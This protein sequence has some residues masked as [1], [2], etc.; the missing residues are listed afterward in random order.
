MKLF[1]L[2]LNTTFSFLEST[3]TVDNAIKKAVEDK[4]EYLIFSEKNNFFSL[5]EAN[6]KC[7]EVGI[8][9]VFGLEISTKID[10]LVFDYNLFAKNQKAFEELKVISYKLLSN[11]QLDIQKCIQE[12]PDIIFIEHPHNSYFKQTGKYINKPNY[13]IG[14]SSSELGEYK[15][16]LSAFNFVIFN[17]FNALNYGDY[18]ILQLLKKM[19]SQDQ[20]II[21]EESLNFNLDSN[22]ISI[23]S[24]INKT[25]ELVKSLYF[26]IEYKNY[27]L[28]KF[29]NPEG[30]SSKDYLKKLISQKIKSLGPVK[31]NEIYQKRL[32]HEYSIITNL[33]FEDYFL[34]MQDWISWAKNNNI[35]IGPGRGS[36]AGSLVSYLLGITEIDPIKY[37][38]IFERFLNPKRINMPDIDVDVQDDKR[39]LIIKYL[40]DK[41][42]YDKVA[43]IVTFSTLGKKSA[44]RDVLRAY[45]I[46][47]NKINK[48]SKLISQNDISLQEEL[49]KNI[50]LV[51]E[52]A[53]LKPDD[54]TFKD[55]IVEETSKISGFYRQSGTHAAGIVISSEKII[56]SVP[57]YKTDDNIQQT[58]VSMEFLENY[59]LIKMDILGLKTLTT[60]KEIESNIENKYSLKINWEQIDCNDQKTFELLSNGN[61]AG[62][63]QVESPIMI[64]ALKKIKVDSFEDIATIISINRPGPISHLKTFSDRKQKIEPVPLVSK[65]YDK[66]VAPTYGIIVYQEQ[67]MEIVQKVANMSF[68]EA[69]LLRRIISKKKSSEMEAIEE[70]FI[71]KAIQ[72][73]YDLK[74][75]K[76][77]FKNISKFA[78]YGFN[79]SH[80]IAYAMLT[81]K[82]A[83]LKANYPLE[84]FTSCISSA[85]GAQTTISKYVNE[86]KKMHIGIISPNINLSCANAAIHDNKIVLPLSLIKG[87]GPEIIKLIEQNRQANGTYKNFLHCIFC[88]SQ[89]KSLG[90]ATLELL[91]KSGAFRDFNLSQKTMLSE[92]DPKSDSTIFIKQN[93]QI[94]AS[95]I[96]NKIIN[97]EPENIYEDDEELLQQQEIDILG[98]SYNYY[99]T[100]KYEID[101]LR[102]IDARLNNEYIMVVKCINYNFGTD[103]RNRS[104]QKL[105]FQ[106]SSYQVVAFSYL[107]DMDLSNLK[108]KIVKIKFVKRDDNIINL[109]DWKVLK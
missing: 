108:D 80:A 82:M 88:L 44:I 27:S 57:T 106:D 76:E 95:Q 100:S 23:I 17:K 40:V 89:I 73:K 21:I 55:K 109:K 84:F 14:L 9:P 26:P 74:T 15:N 102:L 77:I 47:P 83:Y 2:H 50:S 85:N 86:A 75:A 78:D 98:Q 20:K 79:K 12:Y 35:S 22:D 54:S 87:I 37:N 28:A 101:G 8:K 69:D 6:K 45:E 43:N 105:D 1:N 24:L 32:V 56:K 107:K 10:N 72:N 67:I 52:L 90:K 39:D 59:G 58:Q 97:F 61:T 5:A 36:A 71:S 96:M 33:K 3:I 66:I 51:K 99:P 103:K 60:I 42:G 46:E 29:S 49:I 7:Q 93:I 53:Q 38:L 4:A 31:W 92:I 30:L 68:E 65:E 16:Q 104:Y 11:E 63:F 94:N 91:I 48:I 70:Q 25:N 81:F 19:N 62:I 18:S 64:K 13:F 34:I 41:Y